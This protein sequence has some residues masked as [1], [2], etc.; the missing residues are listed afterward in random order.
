MIFNIGGAAFKPPVLN[1]GY[2]KDATAYIE[3][4]STVTFEVV[5]Q[6]QGIPETYAYQ[7]FVDGQPVD[8]ANGSAY[9]MT[10]STEISQQT[11]YC[12]VYHPTGT[13]TSRS[14]TLKTRSWYPD[15]DYTGEYKFVKEGGRNW[16]L[17][18]LSSGLF[19]SMDGLNLD[20]FV[21]GGGGGGGRLSGGGGGYAVTRA[22]KGIGLLPPVVIDVVVGE[23]GLPN[24]TPQIAGE[25]GGE[26]RF[27]NL[28]SASG[29]KGGFN[30]AG[31][32]GGSGGG[33]WI[34]GVGG[35][36]GNSGGNGGGS[37]QGRP[38]EW[39][40]DQ[41]GGTWKFFE[42]NTTRYS[43]GGGA[44]TDHMDYTYGA[45][46]G[47]GGGGRGCGQK[48]QSTQGADGFGGGGGGGNGY[49]GPPSRGGNGIV[50]IRNRREKP[51][52]G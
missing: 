32:N 8:G 43:G 30:A 12:E 2:P 27:G 39:F 46:G 50:I 7:W 44:G 36:N 25:T 19:T 49:D 3:E 13:L 33:S 17:H 35:T 31:G 42:P 38:L 29:G 11:V 5:F 16:E 40:F 14:A 48:N 6:T 1:A 45:S 9:S 26:S 21:V 52:Q 18:F 4:E 15:F 22:G 28:L 34:G 24:N 47:Y 41:N 23:G 20:I 10:S 37:G 51:I